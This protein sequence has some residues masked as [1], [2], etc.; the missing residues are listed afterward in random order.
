MLYVTGVTARSRIEVLRSSSRAH[1]RNICVDTEER[2]AF[3]QYMLRSFYGAVSCSTNKLTQRHLHIERFLLFETPHVKGPEQ[4]KGPW[5]AL[6]QQSPEAQGLLLLDAQGVT[7][8]HY[9]SSRGSRIRAEHAMAL[10]RPSVEIQ[11]V[12]YGANEQ[13]FMTIEQLMP[14]GEPLA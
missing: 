9:I 10:L 4:F 5:L 2:I 8:H 11:Q 13:G 1:T 6:A 14:E 7:E 3:R 12:S